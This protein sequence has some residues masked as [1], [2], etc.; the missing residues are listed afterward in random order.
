MI[1]ADAGRDTG[2]APSS[3]EILVRPDG[4][5]GFRVIDPEVGQAEGRLR[6]RR[7]A[8]GRAARGRRRAAAPLLRR[9]DARDRPADR[10]GRRSISTAPRIETRRSAGCSTGSPPRARSSCGRRRRSSSSGARRGS[11]LTRRPRPPGDAGGAARA[12]SWP[13][14]PSSRCSTS[15]RPA[16]RRAATGCRS[17]SPPPAAPLHRVRRLSYSALALFERCSYRYYAERVAGLRETRGGG[18]G[19][20]RRGPE[21]DRGRRRGAPPARARRSRR[22]GRARTSSA[23]A[24]WYPAV[25]DDELERIARV[26]RARTASRSSRRG[27]R[28][29][30]DVRPGAAVRVRARRRPAARPARRALARRRAR[31]RPRL[32]DELAGRRHARGDRRGRL[33]PAAARLRT[34]VL[35]GR[36]RR[37]R[38]R[39]P[40]PRAARRGRLDHV[41]AARAAAARV[42]AVGGDRAHQ[43]AASSCRPRASSTCAGCPAL[44]LVCAGP[45]L[46]GGALAAAG[47]RRC[48]MP[49]SYVREA[50]RSASARRRRASAP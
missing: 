14:V 38:G 19:G 32:Q 5:F 47:A 22:A 29:S 39:L 23:C 12:R 1:V 8:R 34:R 9:D 6:L 4:S 36:R 43:R 11:S 28:R 21:G 46:G 33:P 15:C 42:R 18:V 16:R 20:R 7:G 35:P 41:R 26:R 50:R 30:P 2:G 44:D 31:A 45:R 40:L 48:H 17:S 49:R 3:D 37:G 24:T 13:R 25:T 10:L 27:S